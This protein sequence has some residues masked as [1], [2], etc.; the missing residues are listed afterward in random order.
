MLVEGRV[1]G[2][3]PPSKGAALAWRE[4]DLDAVTHNV[5]LLAA[6][7]APAEL[8][9]VVKADAYSHGAGQV[10][11][12]ALAAGA[13]RLGVAVLEEAF[14]LRRLGIDAPLLAWLAAPG[15]PYAEA[16][17]L[18]IELGAHSCAQLDEIAEAARLAGTVV[19][20]HLKAE[21][22]MWRGGAATEWAELVALAR[23]YEERGA[24]RVLG[25]WSHLACADSPD[26]P[27][28]DSQLER[29]LDAVAVADA[30]GLR[31]R[32]RHLANSAAT[33]TRPDMHFDLV[34]CGLAVY[35]INPL[36]EQDVDLDLRPAMTVK[37]RVAHVKRAPGGVGVSYSHTYRT[38][39][40]TTLAV[41]PLGYADGVP[42]VANPG[43]PVG[44]LGRPV[45]IAGRVCMDQL[46]LDVGD[47]PAEP[48]DEITLLGPGRDGEH[49]A[50]Q[51][52]TLSGRSAYDMLTGFARRRV[53]IRVR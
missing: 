39:G 9:V 51:W 50:A 21:T 32:F 11:R 25:V 29:F 49:T 22:G 41:V 42:V 10:A 37:A 47:L 5:T 4:V 6:Q 3:G 31:P 40:A 23:H 38:A 28:N 20:V 16:I 53:P 26:D 44:H 12:A 14:E 36:A 43:A 30:A 48:G 33:L 45:Q 24:L 13:T 7:C 19:E 52:A 27:A 18:N 15:A 2:L 34:R 46:V 8:M 1:G 17:G 35:G